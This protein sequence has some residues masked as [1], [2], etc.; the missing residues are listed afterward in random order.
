MAKTTE[1]Y[2]ESPHF[3]A[4]KSPLLQTFCKLFQTQA[5]GLHGWKKARVFLVLSQ[6]QPWCPLRY[7]LCSSFFFFCDKWYPFR[8]TYQPNVH[9]RQNRN[10]GEK[11]IPRIEMKKKSKLDSNT[12]GVR[13]HSPTITVANIQLLVDP[14]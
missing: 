9:L 2:T 8:R 10:G 3:W 1:Q 6:F 7:R 13:H 5:T 11:K 14:H 4:V 12:R